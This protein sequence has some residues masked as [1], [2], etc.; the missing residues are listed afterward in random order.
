M[1]RAVATLLMAFAFL[2]AGALTADYSADS[3]VGYFAEE[4]ADAAED[5]P[6]GARR[7]AHERGLEAELEAEAKH[8][9][10]DMRGNLYLDKHAR[11][12]HIHQQ[13]CV[14]EFDLNRSP[15]IKK[16]GIIRGTKVLVEPPFP[17]G[18]V[19]PNRSI[20]F[21]NGEMWQ[22]QNPKK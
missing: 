11:A 14:M 17:E 18:R 9:C 16:R 15:P 22:N 8:G 19:L 3:V 20:M 1:A 13:G 7:R 4:D 6:K 2:R 5:R 10:P 21:E 12:V